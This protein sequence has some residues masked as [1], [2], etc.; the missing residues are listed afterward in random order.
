[1]SEL[2]IKITDANGTGQYLDLFAGT[3]ISF[4]INNPIF[5]TEVIQGA[6]SFPM[7]VPATSKNKLVLGLL[8]PLQTADALTVSFAAEVQEGFVTLMTGTMKIRQL[9]DK[10]IQVYFLV[11]QSKIAEMAGKSLRTLDFGGRV[12]IDEAYEY[13]Y[14]EIEDVTSGGYGEVQ[15]TVR[16]LDYNQTFVNSV[17][18]TALLL[19]KQI[20]DD[21]ANSDCTVQVYKVSNTK[22]NLLIKDTTAGTGS[23]LTV[24]VTNISGPLIPTE[25]KHW[26]P[27]AYV[28]DNVKEHMANA[29]DGDSERYVCT[30]FPVHNETFYSNLDT[31]DKYQNEYTGGEF[32][33]LQSGATGPW[34]PVTPFP[35]LFHVM[36]KIWET[37]EL[38]LT[39]DGF[40]DDEELK[41]LVLFSTVAIDVETDESGTPMYYNADDYDVAL[42]LP[43]ETVGALINGLQKK[44]A[45]GFFFHPIRDEVKIIPLKEVLAATDAQDWTD[46]LAPG[47][48]ID[49]DEV[50]GFELSS[51]QDGND[52]FAQEAMSSLNAGTLRAA[53]DDLEDLPTS[54]N[55]ANDL[56][57]VRN[58]NQYWK[59]T[60]SDTTDIWTYYADNLHPKRIDEGSVQQES[61]IGNLGQWVRYAGGSEG[62]FTSNWFCFPQVKQVGNSP[63]FPLGENAFTLRL[64]F[65]RGLQANHTD[66]ADIPLGQS[67]RH[68]A[69]GDSTGNYTLSWREA[70]G[71]YEEWWEDWIAFRMNT[72]KVT[73]T[74]KLTAADLLQLDLSKKVRFGGNEYLLGK[75]SLQLPLGKPA[76]VEFWKV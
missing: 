11:N 17:Y 35:Y 16:G 20:T 39:E 48:Q 31:T 76:K 21:V 19:A 47:E 9:T 42:Q 66:T 32:V 62:D 27:S 43:D 36:N 30:F 25:L 60:L 22:C 6:Y 64:L 51:A 40:F 26:T 73:R 2:A 24:V 53:V 71:L 41:T 14:E 28:N 58:V 52:Q 56:R 55:S 37:A 23:T 7:N 57:W 65:Y 4:Q 10:S 72:V 74:V 8:A 5:D 13:F 49:M 29:A 1:M 38:D 61:A 50:T 34:Y 68:N 44:F 63:V 67:G 69:H 46:K 59:V 15:F 18:A 33:S 12:L 3:V 70:G 54:S 75:I 45:L